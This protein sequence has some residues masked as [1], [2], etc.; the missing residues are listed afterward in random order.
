MSNRLLKSVALIIVC[1]LIIGGVVSNKVF[2]GETGLVGCRR[3]V[4]YEIESG[5]TLTG[6]AEKF[7]VSLAQLIEVNKLSTTLIRPK[8]ILIIPG[9]VLRALP[10]SLSQGNIS[11]DDIMLLARAIY[12]EARGE[13]FTGQVAVGSVILNRVASPLFPDSIGEVIMQ[14]NEYVYQFTPVADGS[15]NLVPDETA[16]NAALQAL[17]GEDPT[18]GAL[19]FYNPRIASDRWIR[20]LP[21]IGCIGNHVFATGT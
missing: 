12:A 6:I 21:V 10:A 3:L 7:S 16:V 1:A 2:A 13:S 11:R 4:C 15:I 5:D 9:Q 8:E 20:T 18:N 14:S 17:M 19:F